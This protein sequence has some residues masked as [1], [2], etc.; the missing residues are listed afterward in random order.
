MKKISVV[1]TMLFMSIAVIVHAQG[2]STTTFKVYG[3]CESCKARIEKA[4]KAAGAT[5]ADWSEE[6][7][8]IEVSFNSA[9]TSS[10]KIQQKIAAVGHDTEKYKSLE[11]AYN[12]L[13]GCCKYER[14]AGEKDKQQ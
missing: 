4:A 11:N 9:K 3:N 13:P 12:K 1:M 2:D 14:E 6:T 10:D 5:R 8:M 7:K